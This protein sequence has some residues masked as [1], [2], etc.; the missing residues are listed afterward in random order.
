MVRGKRV[1]RRNIDQELE[2]KRP[3]SQRALRPGSLALPVAPL[4][5]HAVILCCRGAAIHRLG[6]P[7][8]LR[9]PG[10]GASHGVSHDAGPHEGRRQDPLLAG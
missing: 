1:Q 6:Q 7:Q 8:A 10:G 9:Q 4:E 3:I 2:P 5:R